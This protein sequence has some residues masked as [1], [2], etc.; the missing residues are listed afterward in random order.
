MQQAQNVGAALRR[1][2][3][4]RHPPAAAAAASCADLQAA[5]DELHGEAAGIDGGGGVQRGHHPRQRSN[6]VLMPA[7]AVGQHARSSISMRPSS[8]LQ[9]ILQSE[10]P[11]GCTVKSVQRCTP[12]A[13]VFLSSAVHRNPAQTS[14]QP[15]ASACPCVMTTA[16]ILSRHCA[17]NEVSGRIFCMPR[18]VKL[19]DDRG[20][21]R[22]AGG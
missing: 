20:Q 14:T 15:P 2:I 9:H 21:E 22:E 7:T 18:S 19:G 1:C 5:L 12:S 10:A 17:R 3:A 13:R 6:V 8:H 16:S 4:G 11:H